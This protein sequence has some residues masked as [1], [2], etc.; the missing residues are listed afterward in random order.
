M[1][2]S[3]YN[4]WN[5]NI[6]DSQHDFEQPYADIHDIGSVFIYLMYKF[7]L[8]GW[9]RVCFYRANIEEFLDNNPPIQWIQLKPDLA[10]GEVKEHYRAGI[11]GIR[12]SLHDTTNQGPIN[13]KDYPNW[14]VKLPKR[15]NII[16]L[17]AFVF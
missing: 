6:A 11:L 7:K 1:K 5:E 13:W 3:S 8:G 4:R 2:E 14:N 16:K 15:P 9:K 10:I 17:R 12:L